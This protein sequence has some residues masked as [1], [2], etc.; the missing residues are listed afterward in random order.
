MK[1]RLDGVTKT[2]LFSVPGVAA[3]VPAQARNKM[4]EIVLKCDSY[5]SVETV[6]AVLASLP[7][8]KIIQSGV[9]LVTQA[10]LL[11]ARTGSGLVIGFNTGISPALY[12]AVAAEHLEIR[13]YGVIYT[14]LN[15]VKAILASRL[16]QRKAEDTII[17]TANVIRLFPGSRHGIIVGCEIKEGKLLVG[18]PLRVIAPAGII[19]KGRLESMHI[20]NRAVNTAHAGQQVGIKIHHFEQ[21][22]VGDL[23]ECFKPSPSVAGKDW[24]PS[25][26]VIHLP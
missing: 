19:Y 4:L 22:H 17:G 18:K 15:D 3:V 20:E 25:G 21:I 5:G 12:S 7:G 11:M 26:K 6:N 16:S 10:D 23:V 24:H 13:L 8:L 9:G 2:K 14:L 1:Q